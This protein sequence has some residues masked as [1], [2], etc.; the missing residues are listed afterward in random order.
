[1]RCLGHSAVLDAPCPYIAVKA[2]WN[3]QSLSKWERKL[4]ECL[5]R[6]ISFITWHQVLREMTSS[7][8]SRSC[9]PSGEARATPGPAKCNT[10]GEAE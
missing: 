5:S 4:M 3:E 6:V 10:S 1:M 2:P 8:F 7:D 9:L